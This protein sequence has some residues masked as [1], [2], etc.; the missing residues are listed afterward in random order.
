MQL[1]NPFVRNTVPYHRVS[2]E[3]TERDDDR[4]PTDTRPS[5]LPD[6]I[7]RL[8]TEQGHRRSR[9]KHAFCYALVCLVSLF[10]GVILGQLFRLEVEIDGYPGTQTEL[11]CN[12]IDHSPTMIDSSVISY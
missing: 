3:F 10:T 9:R 6:D 5:T 1:R 8:I 11:A 2:K 12:R 7:E 4:S